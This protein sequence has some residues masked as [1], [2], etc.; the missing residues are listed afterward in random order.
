MF[1]IR[2]NQLDERGNQVIEI[3]M[4]ALRTHRAELGDALDLGEQFELTYVVTSDD[5]TKSGRIDPDAPRFALVFE[6]GVDPDGVWQVVVRAS[7][8]A[9]AEA[10]TR[11]VWR[12]DIFVQKDRRLPAEAVDEL[13]RRF[14]PIFVFSQKERYY[15][16]S[17]ETLFNHPAV[18]ESDE[19]MHLKTVLGKTAVPL[20]R[21]GDFMRWNGHREYL[22]DWNLLSMKHSTFAGICGEPSSS[23]V[24]YSY[25]EDPRSDRFFINYHLLYAFD[26]KVGLARA[27]GVGPHVFDRESMVLVFEDGTKP[28][29]MVISGHLENQTIFFLEKLKIWNQGRIRVRFDDERTVKL[30]SHPIVAVAEGSHALYPTS[31]IYKVSVLSEV[32]GFLHRALLGEEAEHHGSPGIAR[33]QVMVPADV[34]GGGIVQYKLSSLGLDRLSSRIDPGAAGY[35]GWNGYLAFSGYWVDVPGSRNERF[36]PFT[37]KEREVQDWVD[38][39]YPWEWDDVPERYHRNNRLILEFLEARLRTG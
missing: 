31:G 5:R 36:P 6:K 12:Q 29:S 11:E 2:S 34:A 38:G 35:D 13:A 4:R 16:V 18:R 37:R 32:A 25:L 15:P 30:A 3:E 8:P 14:A 39:A 33:E 21:L 17:L 27:T 1:D 19:V 24:Y 9:G 7:A 23:T 26:T 10:R 20:S 28:T 22:L